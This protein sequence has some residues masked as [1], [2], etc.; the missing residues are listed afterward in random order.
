[1]ENSGNNRY[2]LLF[3]DEDGNA[4]AAVIPPKVTAVAGKKKTD[5]KKPQPSV[6]K[7]EK[8]NKSS[9]LNKN[10]PKAKVANL[11][12][13]ANG[14]KTVISNGVKESRPRPTNRNLPADSNNANAPEYNNELPKRQIREREVRGPPSRFRNNEKF[15]K[16]EFDRQSGSDKTGKHIHKHIYTC[17][18][19]FC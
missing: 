16:R 15:G 18:I 17:A 5:E 4:N 1:M 8:E 13:K 14:T 19:H 10:N 7:T 6:N 9:V 2:E 3:M 12:Q 11:G